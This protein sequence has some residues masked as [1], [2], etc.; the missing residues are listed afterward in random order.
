MTSD[1]YM[2][3]DSLLRRLK[4]PDNELAWEEF[5]FYYKNF[6]CSII[7]K[8]GIRASDV[9]DLTQRVMLK[10]WKSLPDFD[11]NQKKG[12]FRSWL[13]VVTRNV[14]YNFATR[15][16]SYV[17]SH[18]RLDNQQLSNLVNPEIEQVIEEEWRLHVASLAFENISKSTSE[19][20]LEIFLSSVEGESIKAIAERL[21][22][23]E[24]TVCRYKNRVKQKLVAEIKSLRD[25][26]E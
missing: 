9:D 7:N 10:V 14:A 16:D 8:V 22:M 1:T 13:Y 20:S 25:M 24:D 19:L 3:K 23:N 12:S 18:E 15:D 21:E 17:H 26:L 11:Y 5:C 6:I 4:N 2:T